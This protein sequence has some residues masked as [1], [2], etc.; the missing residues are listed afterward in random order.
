MKNLLFAGILLLCWNSYSSTFILSDLNAPNPNAEL[1][2]AFEKF[3]PK[4]YAEIENL[5]SGISGIEQV[6]YCERM[7]IF[8]FQ[9][10]PEIYQTE[11]DAFEAIM[12]KTRE[13][14]PLLKSGSSIDAVKN[15][16]NK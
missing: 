7:N 3:S 8:Y 15:E 10:D 4:R 13:F 9:Y 6:G 11:N 5:I 1:I 14:Q 12:V 2:V 16:C